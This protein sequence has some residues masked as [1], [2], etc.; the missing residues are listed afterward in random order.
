MAEDQHIKA[1]KQ[2]NK[3]EGVILWE[4]Y[5]ISL[6]LEL[7]LGNYLLRK[8]KHSS[9]GWRWKKRAAKSPLQSAILAVSLSHNLSVEW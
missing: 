7:M 3:F 1:G 5:F 6:Q 2:S 8:M 9:V 4:E